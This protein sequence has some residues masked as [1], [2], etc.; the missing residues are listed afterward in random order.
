LYLKYGFNNRWGMSV[1]YHPFLM[2]SYY[3][4]IIAQFGYIGLLI[5]LLIFLDIFMKVVLKLADKRK[6]YPSLFLIL[7]CLI[8]GIG[9]GT[10][11]VWGCSV[12]WI[13]GLIYNTKDKCIEVKNE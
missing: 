12:F 8:E 4:Q 11:S 3:P 9:F 1:D 6:K 13:V 10:G 5:Y 2:D 7:S